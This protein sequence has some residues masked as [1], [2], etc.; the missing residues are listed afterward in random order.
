MIRRFA[1]PYARAFMQ[2]VPS[3][4]EAQKI[5]DELATFEKVR[6]GSAELADVFARPSVEVAARLAV[7][8]EIGSRLTLS[9]LAARI[10]EVLVRSQRVN[11]MASILEAFQAMIHEATG[12]AVADVRTAHPL[13]AAEAESL[14]RSLEQRFGRKIELRLR[15]DP[16][17]LGGFVAQVES[18]VYDASAVGLLNKIRES[19][20]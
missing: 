17:L 10:L 19:I 6:A 18:E 2:V 20:S 12:V 11:E 1:R 9:A 5:H 15:T 13:A 7:A 3:P 14:Q 4:A 8:R 16:S